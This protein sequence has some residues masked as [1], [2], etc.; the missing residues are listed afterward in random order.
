MEWVALGAL[1][2]AVIAV[3]ALVATGRLELTPMSDPVSSV[4]PL[5]MPERP[6]SADV[7]P[8]RVGTTI[9]GYAP[10]EV[11]AALD[12]RR[13]RLAEQERELSLRGPAP[14]TGEGHVHPDA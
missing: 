2:V 7:D 8:L 5:E 13:D 9:Y 1:A 6:T 14:S 10:D 11:D 12:A 4:P 3:T